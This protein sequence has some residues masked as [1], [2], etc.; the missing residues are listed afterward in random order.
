MASSRSGSAS[1]IQLPFAEDEEGFL[2]N[3]WF[4]NVRVI[5]WFSIKFDE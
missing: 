4:E 2:Q 3:I 5:E 1:Q